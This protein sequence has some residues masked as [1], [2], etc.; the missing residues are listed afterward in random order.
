MK[1]KIT[2]YTS[3]TCPYCKTVKE[4]LE[5]EKIKFKDKDII[6]F[7]EEWQNVVA[8]TN[9]PQIPTLFFNGEYHAP[10]RDYFSPEHLITLIKDSKTSNHSYEARC[11][12][13][14]KTMNFH[15]S[16]AF[17]QLN[18]KLNEIENKL[19]TEKDEH[20]STS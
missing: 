7:K 2:I 11:F 15:M 17:N 8:L 18:V 1:E 12:Q 9:M 20:K 4:T 14:M 19:N 10:G 13:Q 16:Q 3:E 6:K 5:K